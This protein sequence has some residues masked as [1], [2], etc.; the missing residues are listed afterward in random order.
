MATRSYFR[1][2]LALA[3]VTLAASGCQRL[4]P[5]DTQPLDQAGMWY[6]SVQQLRSLDVTQAEIAQLAL[7]RDAGIS[8]GGCLD[9]VK[10]SRTRNQP[11]AE[12]ETV[13]SLHSAGMPES[14][15]LALDRLGQLSPW[16]G[17]ALALRLAGMS[18]GIVLA[19]AQRRVGGQAI[20][21]GASLAKLK[22]TGLSDAQ[23]L[24]L[25]QRGTTDD[26]A[27]Q[28]VAARERAAAPPGFVH[29]HRRRR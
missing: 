28:I 17:Q 21:S 9:L 26:E 20:L 8:D 4:K 18:E 23:L 29:Y 16:G 12:G 1:F 10:I 22:D 19:L 2:L 27:Q 7:A 3:L 14:D 5:L 25:I 13:A 11:F 24:E 15:I 6:G